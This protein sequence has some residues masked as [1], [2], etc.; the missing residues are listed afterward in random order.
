MPEIEPAHDDARDQPEAVALRTSEPTQPVH[1]ANETDL[2]PDADLGDHNGKPG[3]PTRDEPEHDALRE[4]AR[5]AFRLAASFCRSGAFAVAIAT[6][7]GPVS[8]SAAAAFSLL[9]IFAITAS[10]ARSNTARFSI[11][12]F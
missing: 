6:R 9:R 7:P 1:A 2:E 12:N 10:P 8:E 5:Y 4:R 3:G 11:T